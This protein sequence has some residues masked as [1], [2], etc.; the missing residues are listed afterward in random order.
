[1]T[2]RKLEL[3]EPQHLLLTQMVFDAQSENEL[4]ICI[5]CEKKTKKKLFYSTIDGA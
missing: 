2:Q 5:Q 3:L 4:N 1:M